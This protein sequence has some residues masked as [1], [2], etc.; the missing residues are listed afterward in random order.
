MK[1]TGKLTGTLG[2]LVLLACAG[3]ARAGEP[4]AGSVT[5]AAD[6]GSVK[7]KYHRTRRPLEVVIH[8]RRRHGGYSYGVF[9]VIGSNG[10]SIAPYARVKQSPGGPFDEGFFFDS[11]MGL[12]GGNSPYQH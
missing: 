8:A 7:A 12:H 2:A 11:G 3:F 9:E 4:L 1:H 10:R 5:L 6:S